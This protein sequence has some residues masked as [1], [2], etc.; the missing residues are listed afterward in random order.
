MYTAFNL[1]IAFHDFL[2]LS[3]LSLEE[4]SVRGQKRKN[5]LQSESKLEL[6]RFTSATGIIDGSGLS[7]EWFQAVQSDI[8]ISHSHND[9]NIAFALA[10]W[11]KTEFD[12][13]VFLDEC[14]WGSADELLKIMDDK[15]CWR[16]ESETYCYKTRNL[17]TSH[18][19]AMLSTA[20]YSVMDKTEVVLFLNTDES[21]PRIDSTIKENSEYTLSPWI[22]QEL[23]ATKLL[24]VTDWSEY[25]QSG[26][27]EHAQYIKESAD[28]KIAYKT[29]VSELN[30]LDQDALFHWKS[31]YNKRRFYLNIWP[32]T[33][34]L[35]RPLNCLYDTVFGK[36]ER[37]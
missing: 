31:N 18:V 5:N 33:N 17:T 16:P 9:A 11:L 35:D 24:R 36:I 19:H 32:S 8:F 30:V 29:P 7:E 3:A 27:L 13:D 4:L 6:E 14:I 28:L 20:I 25:R 1:K 21:I 22:Y 2:N 34:F 23:M 10:G 12:L 15:H 37:N 26:V